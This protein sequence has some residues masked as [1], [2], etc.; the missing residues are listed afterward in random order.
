ME[1][2]KEYADFLLSKGFSKNTRDAYLSDVEKYLNFCG[3]DFE[4]QNKLRTYI[5]SLSQYLSPRS[6]ARTISSL[7]SFYNFLLLRKK[8][9]KDLTVMLTLPK[10]PPSLPKFLTWEEIEKLMN[11]PDTEKP[12]GLRDR[13]MLELLYATGMRA[14]E[15]INL[16]E[17]DVNIED[18][19]V[20]V[21]GKG[22]KERIIPFSKRARLWVEEY[23]KK[24][25]SLICKKYTPYLFI[26]KRCKPMT[27]Q[28]LWMKIKEY[29]NMAGI[30]EKIWPHV[31]RHTF[32]THMLEGGAD[33]RVIQMML[34]HASITTTQV[35][36]HIDIQ[37][38]RRIYDKFHPRS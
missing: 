27:R 19:Y 36:T 32:A 7:R 9:K 34:G 10:L 11:A 4:N 33:L 25:K 17:E 18:R 24:G 12:E 31:L 22:E 1:I 2:L 37:R 23:L 13:A 6:S 38:L 21:I 14:S 26:T 20:R 8:V 35:Y 29:G 5:R 16:K 15:I 28:A 3:E 30:R